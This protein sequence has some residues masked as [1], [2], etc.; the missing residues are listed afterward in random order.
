[1]GLEGAI[2]VANPVP[3]EHAADSNAIQQATDAALILAK[4]QGVQGKDVTPFL[5]QQVA[6]ATGGESLDANRALVANNAR[7]G[8]AIA[9]AYAEQIGA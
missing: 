8:A 1:M 6:K 5:L 9:V 4:K 3:F 7:L 2:L